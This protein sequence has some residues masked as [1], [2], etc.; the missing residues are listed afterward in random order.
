[1]KQIMIVIFLV[2]A[3]FS[4]AKN[5]YIK[6]PEPALLEIGYTRILNR[7]STCPHKQLIEETNLRIGK[8][9][10]FYYGIKKFWN[11]S[12]P[13]FNHTLYTDALSAALSEGSRNGDPNALITFS[14]T[15]HAYVYKNYPEGMI[16]ECNYFDMTNW[17]YE[18]H[19][20]K[21]QWEIMDSI[22]SCLGYNCVYATSNFRGRHWEAWFTPNIPVSDGPWKLCNLPGLILEAKDLTGTYS[23]IATSIRQ[24]GIGDVGFMEYQDFE[25]VTRDKYFNSWWKYKNSNFAAKMRA[26]MGMGN[27]SPAP[28]K[29]PTYDMEE[30]NYDHN[31]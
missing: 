9:K 17:M 2:T 28:K 29:E 14:G 24:Q 10:S 7:D 27:G 16:T 12:L 31:L 23:F 4:F 5:P 26:M 13:R 19:W 8:N 21:P 11:D 25:K 3:F 1:M 18:E 15:Y 6:D 22:K 30:T 20:E